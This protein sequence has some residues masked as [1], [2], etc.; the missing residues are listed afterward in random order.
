M[1]PLLRNEALDSDP[2]TIVLEAQLA[3]FKFLIV[4]AQNLA[5]AELSS[6][7]KSTTAQNDIDKLLF[8]S[9]LIEKIELDDDRCKEEEEQSLT[10]LVDL[11]VAYK[12]DLYVKERIDTL[13]A[14]EEATNSSSDRV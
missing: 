11:L 5:Q 12:S 9:Q 14:L 7:P 2:D 1:F 10:A 6:D 3:L 13:L 8:L 4:K